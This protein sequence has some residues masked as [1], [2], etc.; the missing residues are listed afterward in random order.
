MDYNELKKIV[1]DVPVLGTGTG[2]G[3]TSGL[4][5]LFAKWKNRDASEPDVWGFT[6][7]YTTKEGVTH[8]FNAMNEELSE[9]IDIKLMFA[10]G[11]KNTLTEIFNT[12]EIQNETESGATV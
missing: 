8:M 3:S 2:T 1:A 7:S 6:Q 5:I 10:D 4:Y 11:Q 9:K 12:M